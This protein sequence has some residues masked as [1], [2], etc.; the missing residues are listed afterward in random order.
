MVSRIG[1]EG[2]TRT[3]NAARTIRVAYADAV[4]TVD[5]SATDYILLGGNEL[6]PVSPA[7]QEIE[8]TDGDT[9]FYTV[10]TSVDTATVDGADTA[11]TTCTDAGNNFLTTVAPGC[12]LHNTT[13][14]SSAIV[15][16]VPD[17]DNLKT[18]TLLGGSENDY[19]TSD[20]IVISP[21]IEV[22]VPGIYLCLATGE[23]SDDSGTDSILHFGVGI[24]SVGLDTAIAGSISST[25]VLDSAQGPR[26]VQYS[27][28]VDFSDGPGM[29]QLCAA[30]GTG[31]GV[32][33]FT[34]GQMTVVKLGSR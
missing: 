9:T 8:N 10:N 22:H 23:F 2:F 31:S 19:D 26:S 16:S 12:V 15:L 28:V 25:L 14:G 20:A 27:C 1:Y 17:N 32:I 7:E 21:G 4:L 30:A 34:D 33:D 3:P 18:S 5:T 6:L 24:T 29:I 13:D 11:G